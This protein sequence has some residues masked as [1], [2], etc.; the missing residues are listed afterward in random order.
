METELITDKCPVCGVEVRLEKTDDK[1]Y[2]PTHNRNRTAYVC[3]GSEVEREPPH[4]PQKSP[5]KQ[6]EDAPQKDVKVSDYSHIIGTS[7]CRLCGRKDVLVTANEIGVLMQ[8]EHHVP[9]TGVAK[10]PCEGSNQIVDNPEKDMTVWFDQTKTE[11]VK[12]YPDQPP[13]TVYSPRKCQ[14][15]CADVYEWPEFRGL[16][17][18]LGIDVT[19]STSFLQITLNDPNEPVRVT[20]SYLVDNDRSGQTTASSH[21]GN[22]EKLKTLQDMVN[23]SVFLPH[24]KQGT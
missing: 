13:T 8:C 17:K 1:Y 22:A 9:N 6:G 3:P 5:E 21:P 24:P 16:C 12:L 14:P 18:R 10:I 15:T 2:I 7:H 19:Q 4:L 11:K 20:H 23:K